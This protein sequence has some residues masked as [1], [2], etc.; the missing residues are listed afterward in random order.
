MK[1]FIFCLFI[2]ISNFV[3]SQSLSPLS[4]KIKSAYEEL[5]QHPASVQRQLTYLKV[6]PQNKERFTTIFDSDNFGEL[7]SDYSEYI[8]AFISLAKNY[9][10]EVIDKSI[11][12]GKNLKWRADAT[13][14]MQNSI[15]D[16]GNQ[17]TPLFSKK[18]KALSP[19]E[20]SNL[21]T[22][23]ADVENHKAYPEYQ[24]LIESLQKI[25]ENKLAAK[26]I[27]ARAL[28]ERSNNH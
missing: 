27:H 13:G 14:Q 19:V 10:E 18:L 2:L 15:V 9:P 24:K 12:I 6:F 11:T 3:F 26:F 16:L 22:F 23:L 17:Y 25:G 20:A 7:Y 5:K 21:I 8:D 4:R 28:R 1:A